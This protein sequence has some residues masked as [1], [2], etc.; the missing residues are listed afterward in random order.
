[1]RT[2]N[3]TNQNQRDAQVCMESVRKPAQIRRV[4]DSGQDYI[5]VSVLK[6]SLAL[7]FESLRDNYADLNELGQAIIDSDPEID[8]ELIGKRVTRSNKLYLDQNN[9]IAYRVNMVQIIKDPSGAEIQRRDL[10]KAASNVSGES[11][12]HWSGRKYPKAETIRKFV[13]ARKL[14]IKHVSGLTFDFLYSMAKDL[15]ESDSLMFVGGGK[16][17][18]QPLILTQGGEPYRGFLEGRVDGDKYCL[19]LHLTNLEVKVVEP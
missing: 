9:R 10:T 18:N 14:Q 4:L 17:G 19:I 3:L 5:S 8:M 11:V 2:I 16:K 15:D 6:Q 13:F 1:M 12:V 7:A